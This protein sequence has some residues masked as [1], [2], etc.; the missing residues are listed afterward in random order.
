MNEHPSTL[1]II[2]EHGCFYGRCNRSIGEVSCLWQV[3]LIF[4]GNLRVYSTGY[5][6]QFQNPQQKTSIL[7]DFGLSWHRFQGLKF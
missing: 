6:P 3:L 1:G 5:T 4:D 7:I 2:L